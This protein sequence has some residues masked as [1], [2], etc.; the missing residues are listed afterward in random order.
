MSAVTALFLVG[1]SHPIDGGLNPQ[2]VVKLYEGDRAI[3]EAVSLS[4][5]QVERSSSSGSPEFTFEA[6]CRL[7]DHLINDSGFTTVGLVTFPGS[8]I[9]NR[10]T[11][12]LSLLSSKANLI[13]VM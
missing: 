9:A 2:F 1:T 6:G 8:V 5:G 10:R 12:V 13:Q 11:E 3:W 4:D 7:V